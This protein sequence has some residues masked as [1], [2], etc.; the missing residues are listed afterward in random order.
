MKNLNTTLRIFTASSVLVLLSGCGSLFGDEGYFR[1]KSNDYKKAPETA[2]LKVPAGMSEESLLDIYA[3]PQVQDAVVLAGQFEVPRP[4][5]LVAGDSDEIVRIQKL[6]DDSWA[7][8]NMAP[9][10]LWPQVRSFL[11][12]AGVQVA[13]MDARAGIIETTWLEIEDQ[14]MAARFQFRIEQGVQR[15]NSELHV[16]QMN[17]AGDINSWPAGSDN[18]VLENEM[19]RGISQFIADSADTAPVSMIADQGISASGKISLQE[20]ATGRTFIRVGL[21][22]DRAWASLARALEASTFEITDRNRSKGE[23]Y[24]TFRGPD[25]EDDDGWFDWMFGDDEHPLADRDFLVK[26]ESESESSVAI[27]LIPQGSEPVE[28]RQQQALLTMIKS[29]IN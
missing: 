5:P 3:V 19:L 8:I 29:N 11:G 22:Y 9:G 25:E 7:L 16:L 12:A 23:Y 28:P 15:G 24:V 6:G 1:D 2:R 13:R 20:S 27:Y 10:Q 4:S 14:T 17:Q 21:P 26:A 18:P